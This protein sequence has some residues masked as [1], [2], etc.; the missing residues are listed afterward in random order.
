[1]TSVGSRLLRRTAL[2]GELGDFTNAASQLPLASDVLGKEH[3]HLNVA[4]KMAS[5][6]RSSSMIPG[7]S[8]LRIV[9]VFLLM[10]KLKTAEA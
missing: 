6:R 9:K 8:A 7:F 10:W 5:I 4:T 3:L 1:M 2:D